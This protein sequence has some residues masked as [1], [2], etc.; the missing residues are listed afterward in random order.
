[1]E[2]IKMH[3]ILWLEVLKG[4]DYMENIGIGGIIILECISEK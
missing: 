1:M 3:T 4:R 2:E